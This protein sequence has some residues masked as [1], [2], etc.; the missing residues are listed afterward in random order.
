MLF[1]ISLG[2]YVVGESV[3]HRLDPRTKA[4]AMLVLAIGLIQ[5]STLAGAVVHLLLAMGMVSLAGLPS[6]FVVRSLRPFVWLITIVFASHLLAGG[7]GGWTSGL[8]LSGRLLAMVM[9]ASLLSWTTQ[10]LAVVAGLRA[11]GAPLRRIGV[12]VDVSATAVGLA[13][14]FAPV[15]LDEARDILRAQSARGADFRGIRNK[16][17]LLVPMLGTLFERA[18]VRAEVLADAMDSRGYRTDSERTWY[19]ELRLRGI[20]AIA[21]VCVGAWLAVGAIADRGVW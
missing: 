21:A 19:R 1:D 15:A 7:A 20:D 16:I 12:P 14:R 13:L 3:I 10:P 11:L 2:R 6:A 8:A 18:F 17:A 4:I 5:G 9:L